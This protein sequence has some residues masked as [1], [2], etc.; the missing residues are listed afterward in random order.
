MFFHNSEWQA[1]SEE[2]NNMFF[3]KQEDVFMMFA[4]STLDC[5]SACTGSPSNYDVK[6]FEKKRNKY[7]SERKGCTCQ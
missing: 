5:S 6:R 7:T 2:G 4:S 1:V 3:E